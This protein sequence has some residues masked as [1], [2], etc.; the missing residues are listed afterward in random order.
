MVGER[1]DIDYAGPVPEDAASSGRATGERALM[2]AVLA[3]AVVCMSEWRRR[4][5]VAYEARRWVAS[6]SRDWPFSF[7]NLCE[8]LGFD[9]E[10][11]RRCLLKDMP[12]PAALREAQTATKSRPSR[13]RVSW[14]AST[15]ALEVRDR[16]DVEILR[17]RAEGWTFKAIAR[18]FG[19]TYGYVLTICARGR[20]VVAERGARPCGEPAEQVR[21]R[22]DD[23]EIP[24]AARVERR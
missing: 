2:S 15:L 23:A 7:V 5:Q 8:T 13:S 12:S 19:L 4:P 21:P 18:A 22:S 10:R 6:G 24:D 3:D 1:D 16:R 9:P 11:L 14:S 17:R 20:Q